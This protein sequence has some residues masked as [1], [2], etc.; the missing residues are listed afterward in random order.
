MW[1]TGAAFRH[2]FFPIAAVLAAVVSA[3][4]VAQSK[5][6]KT[7]IAPA[8][9]PA[10]VAK[11]SDLLG[12]FDLTDAQKAR[13]AA[14]LPRCFPKLQK[15]L[16]FHVVVLGDAVAGMDGFD[17]DAGNHVKGYPAKFLEQIA[18][19]FY[20]TGGVRV[21]KPSGKHPEKALPL[22]GP[23]IT[24]RNLAGRGRMAFHGL[25]AWEALGSKPL[26]DLVIIGYGAGE[27][28][29]AGDATAFAETIRSLVQT[30]RAAGA[31][32]VI[33][34]PTLTAAEPPELS[35]AS[36]R[37]FSV[38]M[39]NISEQMKVPF[40]D[41]GDL[42]DM[43]RFDSIP[44][45]APDDPAD[46]FETVVASC[47]NHFRWQGVEDYTLPQ[48]RL[49]EQLG[50]RMFKTLLNGETA[51]PWKVKG[52]VANFIS[53]D[54][55][56]A[57]FSIQN[58]AS[59]DKALSVLPLV[60][61]RWLPGEAEPKTVIKAG[62]NRKVELTYDRNNQP[63]SQRWNPFPSSDGQLYLSI[64]IS[65]GIT[66]RIED[67]PMVVS[68]VSLVW[69]PKTIRGAEKTFT[70]PQTVSNNTGAAISG[71][72][73]TATLGSSRISGKIDL[74]AGTPATLPLTFGLPTDDK[75]RNRLEKLIV[76]V[77]AGN[78][79]MRWERSVEMTRNMG[80]KE[81]LPM[82]VAVPGKEASPELTLRADADS[83]ALYLTVDI[84]GFMMEDDEAGI[85]MG[86]T[87]AL[88]ARTYGKRLGPGGVE[89]VRYR[90]GV[91]DGYG[92]TS[93]I[94][95]WAFGTGYAM[96]FDENA[97][98][99]RLLSQASGGRRI[100]LVVPRSYL[101]LHDFTI[102]NGNS[103][104]GFNLNLN[105]YRQPGPA[106]TV[107]SYPGSL[108]YTLTRN[109]RPPDDAESLPVLELSDKPT[110]RWTVIHW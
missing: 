1:V 53:A 105:F 106:E 58:T 30:V 27:A 108:A 28:A 38:E 50:R 54:Q 107:G 55:F 101:Y 52:G 67:V 15:R 44:D 47:R 73:W 102:G 64:L 86:A 91:A 80:L 70:L 41:L 40:F 95:P 13:L 89:A 31:D 76:T 84:G 78:V 74:P 87:L 26:P 7:A 32:L 21:V 93:R 49:H 88:D 2:F 8:A 37:P 42:A 35:L 100:T 79:L 96:A 85:A 66:A 82:L 63:S 20:Y 90:L 57:T 19:Q 48:A 12:S 18:G 10:P 94:A 92:E 65:D 71:A 51:V 46:V 3:S 39:R 110:R 75:V 16:P 59:S 33:A 22:Q 61:A 69:N 99:I 68:P 109:G 97:M 56:K 25:Q 5:S 77:F 11:V 29:A 83:T 62:K 103:H 24:V 6:A 43:I 60:P 9:T 98:P 34:G 17:V 45:A 36:T 104:L 4:V 81:T 14:L 23:E 72:E